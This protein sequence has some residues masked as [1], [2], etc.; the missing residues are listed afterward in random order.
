MAS[1]GIVLF[2]DG[3]QVASGTGGTAVLSSNPYYNI[4]ASSD[5][6]PRFVGYFDEL[7]VW[8]TPLSASEVADFFDRQTSRVSGRIHLDQ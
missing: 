2:V 7:V 4:G 8:D 1:G 6:D 5:T 3:V